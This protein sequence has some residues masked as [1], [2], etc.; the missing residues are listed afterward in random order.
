MDVGPVDVNTLIFIYIPGRARWEQ[1]YNNRCRLAVATRTNV[2]H[3]TSYII[4]A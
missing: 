1:N 4:H 3:D 2:E